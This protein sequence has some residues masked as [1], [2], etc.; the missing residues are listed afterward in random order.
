MPA[1]LTLIAIGLFVAGVRSL[2]SLKR[3]AEPTDTERSDP[4]FTSVTLLFSTANRS[5]EFKLVQ[6]R[7]IWLFCGSIL[8]LYI[9][10]VAFLQSASI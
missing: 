6:R 1:V 4:F 3:I 5:D 7:T 2:A 10:R 8:L 9:A